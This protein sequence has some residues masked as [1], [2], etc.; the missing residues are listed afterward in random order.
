[1][2]DQFK[3]LPL[4]KNENKKRFEINVNGHY[5]FIN[6]EESGNKVA[7]VHTEADP[8]LIGTGAGVAVV[9][10]TLLWLDINNK[11][12]LPYCSFVF[13][14]LQKHLEWKHIVDKQFSAYDKL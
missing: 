13:T 7:L 6:Y 9:E 4:T 11:S 8:K 1:M 5:A 14:Y 10:K 3:T 2:K 12:I